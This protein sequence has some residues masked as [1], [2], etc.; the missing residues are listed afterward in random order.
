MIT[1]TSLSQCTYLKF[2]LPCNTHFAFDDDASL[3]TMFFSCCDM[4]ACALIHTLM[5]RR[6]WLRCRHLYSLGHDGT[7][8]ASLKC[9]TEAAQKNQLFSVE[10]C[11]ARLLYP[12]RHSFMKWHFPHWLPLKIHITRL[13][14]T[15]LWHSLS[16][17]TRVTNWEMMITLKGSSFPSH[18]PEARRWAVTKMK[19]IRLWK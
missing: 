14:I 5:K 8:G 18:F 1:F 9:C 17:Q 11:P 4:Y 3:H 15:C 10:R 19:A 6:Q 7:A 12:S 13:P 16:Y 2:I